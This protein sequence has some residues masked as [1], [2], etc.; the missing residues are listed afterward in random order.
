MEGV[1]GMYHTAI[2]FKK[3]ELLGSPKMIQ[4][5]ESSTTAE[6]MSI[7]IY[8]AITTKNYYGGC[9]ELVRHNYIPLECV[10]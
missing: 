1:G 3:N 2:N 7:R 8:T 5:N 9:Y 4:A 6:L 10:S